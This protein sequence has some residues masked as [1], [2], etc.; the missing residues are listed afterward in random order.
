MLAWVLANAGQ[1][2]ALNGETTLRFAAAE[3]SEDGVG[4]GSFVVV[5]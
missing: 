5:F 3:V 2:A 4:R 1:F